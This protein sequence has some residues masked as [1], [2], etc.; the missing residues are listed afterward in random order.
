MVVLISFYSRALA[1]LAESLDWSLTVARVRRAL[2][3]WVSDGIAA[4][5]RVFDLETASREDSGS[6]IHVSGA[7]T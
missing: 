3:E 7:I 2:G 6:S 4:A 5:P 1:R